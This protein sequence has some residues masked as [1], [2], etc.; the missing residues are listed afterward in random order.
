MRFA[1]GH[2]QVLAALD[3]NA[4]Y[5]RFRRE[6]GEKAAR[7]GELGQAIGYR[8]K[9]DRKGWRVFATTRM[10]DVPVAA[11]HN[12]GAVGL[13]LN[14]DHLAVCETNASGNYVHALSVPLVTYGKSQH[15]AEAV[16]GDAVATVVA[17]A[18]DGGKPV[19]IENLDFR[20]KKD[21][22]VGAS[23]R[24]SRMLSSFSC[25]KVKVCFIS[26]GY[27]EGVDVNQVNP[28]FSSVIGRV[29]FMETLRAQRPPGRSPGAGPSFTQLFRAHPAL[30]GV[31]RR[32]WRSGSLHRTREEASKAR[33]DVLGAI[34]GQLRPVRLRRTAQHRLEKQRGRA[35]PVQA[36][37]RADA[38]GVACAG[39]NSVFLGEIPKRSRLE[40]SGRRSAD[41]GSSEVVDDSCVT[42]INHFYNSS[43]T[44]SLSLN[45]RVGMTRRTAVRGLGQFADTSGRCHAV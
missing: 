42:K 15:Q 26:R 35:N 30:V 18:R 8:F 11:D 9:R 39:I 34:S 13:D 10:I 14:A 6:H 38:R 21:A 36:T 29:K 32:Q 25:G 19:V 23:R 40:L 43:W 44:L 3:S 27:R 16:I 2:E 1:Y 4:E 7:A 28:A 45:G 24:Y 12:R 37:S 33:V 5:A 31:S 22:L 17:Y 20:Q 41:G